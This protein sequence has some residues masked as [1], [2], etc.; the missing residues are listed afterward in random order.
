MSYCS[1]EWCNKHVTKEENV[2]ISE[3]R[4]LHRAASEY[5]NLLQVII[6]GYLSC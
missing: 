5:S 3:G 2:L 1:S 4:T 6:Q